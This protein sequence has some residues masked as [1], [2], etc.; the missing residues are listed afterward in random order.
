MYIYTKKHAHFFKKDFCLRKSYIYIINTLKSHC[1]YIPS[2]VLMVS[3]WH[4]YETTTIYFYYSHSH[5]IVI[6]YFVISYS[7]HLCVQWAQL[8]I[9]FLFSGC[10]WSGAGASSEGIRS[11]LWFWIVGK[12]GPSVFSNR[13]FVW[14]FRMLWKVSSVSFYCPITWIYRTPHMITTHHRDVVRFLGVGNPKLNLKRKTLECWVF[15]GGSNTSPL[16]FRDFFPPDFSKHI[17]HI[18]LKIAAW[19]RPCVSFAIWQPGAFL[20][21]PSLFFVGWGT[22]VPEAY[23]QAKEKLRQSQGGS[24]I[25]IWGEIAVVNRC[26]FPGEFSIHD[27]CFCFCLRK[28]YRKRLESNK[29]WVEFLCH[30]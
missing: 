3:L 19:K 13:I 23:R 30:G 15:G 20:R 29:T 18:P 24:R 26:N 12:A 6:L 7:S 21:V 1:N 9:P 16:I 22:W 17:Y 10:T 5:I 25:T 4:N 2:I 27:F 11:F 8:F 14:N 28:K